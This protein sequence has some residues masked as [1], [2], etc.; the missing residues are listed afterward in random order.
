MTSPPLFEDTIITQYADDLVHIVFSDGSNYKN[1]ARQV[2]EKMELELERTKKWEDN[3][4][5]K[6]NVEKT[7]ITPLGI[8]K[9]KIDK[10]GGIQIDN[11][12]LN[13]QPSAKVLGYTFSNRKNNIIHINNIIRKAKNSLNK[14]RR[15]STAPSKI[16]LT[17]YK[18][19]VRPLL[20]LCPFELTKISTRQKRRIQVI[21][22]NALR[23]VLNIKKSERKKIIDIHS[24]L[25]IEPMNVR[26]DKLATKMLNK[27]KDMYFYKRNNKPTI[28]YKYDDYEIKLKPLRPKSQSLAKR[29]DKNILK[30]NF[31]NNPIKNVT[32]ISDWKPPDSLFK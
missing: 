11:T 17:L 32:T 10:L 18:M 31:V 15:F 29:I 12:K 25:K 28:N 16:K 21:Q 9:Q 4:K 30:P 3:W 27:M 19:I 23:F 1:K 22:N 5:I 14:I 2:K 24:E 20:E 13:F 6:T 8:N 7:I 26:I